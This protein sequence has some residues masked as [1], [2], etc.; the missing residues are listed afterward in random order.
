MTEQGNLEL[1]GLRDLVGYYEELLD[2]LEDMV[3]CLDDLVEQFDKR[4]EDGSDHD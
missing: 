2:Y 1:E 4:H 3:P